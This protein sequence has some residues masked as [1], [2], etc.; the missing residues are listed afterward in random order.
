MKNVSFDNIKNKFQILII[1]S[2]KTALHLQCVCIYY[3]KTYFSIFKTCYK[4]YLHIHITDLKTFF[5]IY[6]LPSI[7][8]VTYKLFYYSKTNF[9]LICNTLINC[10]ISKLNCKNNAKLNAKLLLLI[11]LIYFFFFY[12]LPM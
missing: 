11:A 4:V 9:K 1:Y 5:Y 10:I 3:T 7:N 6:S 2:I 12:K 8:F